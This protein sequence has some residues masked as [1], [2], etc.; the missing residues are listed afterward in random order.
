MYL[1][2]HITFERESINSNYFNFGKAYMGKMGDERVGEY[3][4]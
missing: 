1:P 3:F 4:N 2:G